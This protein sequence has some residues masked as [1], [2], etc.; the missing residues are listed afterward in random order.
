MTGT[1]TQRHMRFV[2]LRDKELP[3]AVAS[4]DFSALITDCDLINAC[5]ALVHLQL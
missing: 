5:P 3:K 1:T 2:T 4:H